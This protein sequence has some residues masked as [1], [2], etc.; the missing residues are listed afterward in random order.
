MLHVKSGFDKLKLHEHVDWL[1]EYRKL[2][3][4]S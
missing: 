1:Y 3:P 2:D 4:K